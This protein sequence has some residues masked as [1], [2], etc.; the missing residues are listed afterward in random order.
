MPTSTLVVVADFGRRLLTPGKD[1]RIGHVCVRV[2]SGGGTLMARCPD[3]CQTRT[4]STSM[5]A[6]NWVEALGAPGQS[7]PTARF[8]RRKKGWSNGQA[9]PGG[10]SAGVIV[11]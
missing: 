2:L 4:Q 10:R 7:P 9:A 3:H 1:C 11:L 5:C 6:G 8:S